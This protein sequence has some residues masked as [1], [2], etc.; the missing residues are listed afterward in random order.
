MNTL[1]CNVK[2]ID[3][4]LDI[5]AI[6]IDKLQRKLSGYTNNIAFGAPV[7]T[8]F[9]VP[10]NKDNTLTHIKEENWYY[11]SKAGSDN[12]TH[13]F[14]ATRDNFE[15]CN[16]YN[17]QKIV[18]ATDKSLN[19]PIIPNSFTEK[20][21]NIKE[22][23]IELEDDYISDIGTNYEEVPYGYRIKID[24]NNAVICIYEK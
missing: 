24:K 1:K 16:N 2:T 10:Y 5:N 21:E 12:I 9:T 23:I 18:A 17:Y 15:E 13:I 11:S 8:Y 7:E 19:L 4:P 6:D 20:N 14:K 3:Y 22:I